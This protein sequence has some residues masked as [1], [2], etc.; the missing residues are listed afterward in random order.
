MRSLNSIHQST[1]QL[2]GGVHPGNGQQGQQGQQTGQSTTGQSGQYQ[3]GGVTGQYGTQAQAMQRIPGARQATGGVPGQTL[4]S[5]PQ[6]HQHAAG[7]IGGSAGSNYGGQYGPYASNLYHGQTTGGQEAANYGTNLAAN[8]VTNMYNGVTTGGQEAANYAAN[9]SG[10]RV[11]PEGY[12]QTFQ[13]STYNGD[14]GPQ[15]NSAHEAYL[16]RVQDA[17]AARRA[18]SAQMA[19][20]IVQSNPSLGGQ[21]GGPPI[22]NPA[23]PVDVGGDGMAQIQSSIDPSTPLYTP[24][25]TRSYTNQMASQA[26]QLGNPRIAMKGVD[27]PG[28]SRD[29][30]TLAAALPQITAARSA[31]NNLRGTIP[32]QDAFANQ[33]FALQGQE[34]Q[35]HE[36]NALANLLMQ[37]QGTQDTERNSAISA[38]L[39]PAMASI[40]G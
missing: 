16:Q 19:Q 2:V 17:T 18:R 36:T 33:Q 39:N 1:G 8:G 40:F 21:P 3:L 14:Y 34:A 22:G 4:P 9:L 35:G 23:P 13:G 31:A 7:G 10:S 28:M 12:H 38:L 24:E 6:T 26:R 20:G 5:I 29:E 15:G 11:G 27:R 32:M 37:L 25:Q 30:G